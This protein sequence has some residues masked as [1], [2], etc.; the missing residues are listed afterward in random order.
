MLFSRF[1]W[2]NF[3]R[4]FWGIFYNYIMP[5]CL[6]DPLVTLEIRPA[7]SHNSSPCGSLPPPFV[8]HHNPYNMMP[9]H[10]CSLTTYSTDDIKKYF[11][12]KSV[13]RMGMALPLFILKG[14]SLLFVLLTLLLVSSEFGFCVQ[15]VHKIINHP[16]VVFIIY[17][18]IREFGAFCL[19]SN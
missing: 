1:I 18:N 12:F 19:S 4:R 11:L 2:I 17:C 16:K 3:A 15:N 10:R 6:W 7:L 9:L 8:T 14:E 13:V 5:I